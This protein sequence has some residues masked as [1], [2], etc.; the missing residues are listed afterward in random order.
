MS[1]NQMFSSRRLALSTRTLVATGF[2]LL[3]GTALVQLSIGSF[4]GL[5]ISDEGMYL[6]SADQP[7]VKSA[8]HN[9]FG[10]YT[11]LIFKLAFYQVW[12]FRV[13]GVLALATVGGLCSIALFRLH[14]ER[15]GKQQNRL[16]EFLIGVIVVP[17]YYAIGLMTPS[18][19]W[20]NLF[21]LCLGVASIFNL[22]N[23]SLRNGSGYV[24]RWSVALTIAIWLGTF[25]KMSTGPGL[26]LLFIIVFSASKPNRAMFQKVFWTALIT[27]SLLLLFHWIVIGNPALAI[28]KASRGQ[29]IL[30]ILDPR[31]TIDFAISDFLSGSRLWIQNTFFQGYRLPLLLIGTAIALVTKRLS[32]SI[33]SV[34]KIEHFVHG[35]GL[36]LLTYFLWRGF[37]LSLWDGSLGHYASQF[38]A[39]SLLIPAIIF[40]T[41]FGLL[42]TRK[43]WD[44][45]MLMSPFVLLGSVCL[46]GFGSNN[47]FAQQVTGASGLLGLFILSLSLLSSSSRMVPIFCGLCLV[48]GSLNTTFERSL[49][50][51]RQL[52]QSEQTQ[53]IE[54]REGSGPLFVDSKLAGNILDLRSQLTKSQWKPRTPLLDM[55]QYSA[56]IV[57]ALDAKPPVTII[58]TVGGMSNV[59]ALSE[60]AFDYIA[61][62]QEN[63]EWTNAWLLMPNPRKG[64]AC[65]LCPNPAVLA[66]L[67]RAFPT[68]Y[69]LVA[70]SQDFLI[71]KPMVQK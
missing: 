71:F 62:H 23:T 52:P 9:P 15:L 50:P 16:V 6:L 53:R 17:F 44:F 18:Y 57:F 13:I 4:H 49:R 63:S 68:D 25:A 1:V 19:N 5:D 8:F 35:L 33:H 32:Q 42:L 3:I 39:V 46:Y 56:G 41:P 12:L 36:I 22:V 43:K 51:Y 60:W 59:D 65:I 61:N 29:N 2:L 28:E 10:D 58:P 70:E 55:T 54:I 66:K 24:K 14:H 26:F 45:Q 48:L 21:A 37:H 27:I 20:L 40:L 11:G 69:K 64:V 38:Q 34:H 67:G 30:I 31:Y 47:G 7:T